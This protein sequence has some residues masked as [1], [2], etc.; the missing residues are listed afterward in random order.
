MPDPTLETGRSGG[1]V[2]QVPAGQVPTGSSSTSLLES[3]KPPPVVSPPSAYS[4]LVPGS[5]ANPK[6]AL[7]IVNAG[8]VVH[9]PGAELMSRRMVVVLFAS[10]TLVCAP[11]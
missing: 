5:Y 2:T 4:L 8:P 9:T 6:S 11:L 7:A 3:K 10:G 1:E